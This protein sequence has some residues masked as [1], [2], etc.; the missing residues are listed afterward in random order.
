MMPKRD[1]DLG[2]WGGGLLGRRDPHLSPTTESGL[3]LLPL[4]LGPHQVQVRPTATGGS[5]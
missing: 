3:Q 1:S 5:L 2:V 4:A